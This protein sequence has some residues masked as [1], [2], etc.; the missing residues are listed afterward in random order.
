MGSIWVSIVSALGAIAAAGVAAWYASKA[1]T[2]ELQAHRIRELEKRLAGSREEVYKPMVDL[3]R[4]IFDS[5]Q[6][7]KGPDDR[8]TLK[9]L[10]EFATW[11]Q[12]YGSDR[13]VRAFHKFMQAAYTEP[14][15]MILLRYMN[16]FILAVRRDIGDPDTTVDLLDLAGIRTTDI[17]A[18]ENRRVMEL[19]ERDLWLE[20]S[21]DPPW[22]SRYS[23]ENAS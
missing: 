7:G 5:G 17:Y 4:Q 12:I 8:K 11:V 6:G 23:S 13:V 9:T 15:A 16:E 14:P 22:G 3:L 18:D 20:H 10:S 21:W 19:P 2:A 1:R